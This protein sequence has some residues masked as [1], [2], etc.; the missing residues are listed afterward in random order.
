[1]SGEPDIGDY[2]LIGDCRSAALVSR[3]GAIDW[4]CL[5]DFDSPAIFCRI[6]DREKGGYWEIQPNAPF[7]TQRRYLDNS[8]V[9]ETLFQCG[10][11]QARMIDLMPIRQ[12]GIGC[13]RILRLPALC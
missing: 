11:A 5:P 8:N 3:D 10:T 1:M 13:V 4:C 9:L 6:L 2:G 7:T 12:D